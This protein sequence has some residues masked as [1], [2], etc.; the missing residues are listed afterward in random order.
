MRYQG[1]EPTAFTIETKRLIHDFLLLSCYF[2]NDF[3]PAIPATSLSLDDSIQFVLSRY[4]QV[5]AEEGNYMVQSVTDSVF[6]WNTS[7]LLKF[8]T[9]CF[10]EENPR[11]GARTT[12]WLR[13]RRPNPNH[14]ESS[15]LEPITL[16]YSLPR[17]K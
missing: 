1:T 2:G 4:C 12:K 17:N 9:L 3:L 7:F 14:T 16:F 6:Y 5:L 15:P 11:M 13:R 8:W 10:K